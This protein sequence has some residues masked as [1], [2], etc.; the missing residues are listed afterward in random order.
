MVRSSKILGAVSAFALGVAL[1]LAPVWSAPVPSSAT[2]AKPLYK[3]AAAPIESRVD[4]L[5]ARMTLDE[6]I[7]QITTVWTDKIKIFD[8]RLQLDPAMLAAQ[9]PNGLGHFTRPSDGKGSFSP[10]VAPGRNPRQTVVLVNGLQKWA[11]TQTRLGIPILFHEEGLHGYAAVG[12]TSF[13]QSIAMASSFDTDML[14]EVNAVIAR[15]IRARGVSLVL[16]PVVDIA[17]DPRWGRIEE[18]YGEDPYLVGEMGVAAVEGLQG[19]GRSRILPDGHVFA[20]LKHLTGHGQPESGTNVGP[21]PISERELRE[22]FFPPFEQV[23]KR[24]GIEAVMA[25]YNEIDGVPSHANRWLLEDILREEWGFR[26]AVVS[27]YSAVDQLMSI[28]HIAANLDEAAIRA[29]DAGVDADLPDGLSYAALGKLVREGKV[30]EAKIDLAVRRML[31]LKFRAG[32]FENPYADA[33]AAEKITNNPQAR[34]L[35]LTAAQRSIT[36]LK[37]DGMLPLKPEGTI[38]VIGP[39][40]AV[41]RLGGYYGQP[42]HTVSI[43]DGIKAKV[44]AK[45]KIVFAQGVKITEDDDWWADS[46]TK[47]DPAENRKLIAQ[48]V[49]AARHVDRIVLTLGDT[50]QSSREGWADNHLGDRPSLDLV[51]EQQE[52]FDALKALGKP[53]TVVLING[54][55]A[56]T[57][58][59]SEQAN[60]ILEGWY[61]GEQGG[62][63]VAD[64][65]FGD[66]NPGGKLPVTV[67]RSVGQLPIFYNYKPSAHRGYLFDTTDPLYPFGFGLSYTTFDLSAPRLSAA[68]IG[69]GGKTT[70]S[71]DVRNSGP[72]A[73]DE[74]V[75]LYIR[76]KI[77]SVTRPVKE[78][79]GFQRITLKPGE[80]RTVTFTVSPESLQMWN[81]QMQR[82]VEPGDF[83]IMTGNSSVALQTAT[84]TVTP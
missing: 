25:S 81:D 50:E 20:T 18:T 73:G 38:A 52:L 78:L 44:G 58:T 63:A 77:S 1:P 12:A 27:D 43:L 69:I 61:L 84:L 28:H 8:D 34:A 2:T 21:A 45:A 7:A 51:G 22:N 59:V 72:R 15:E 62:N 40:A 70:V 54:R 48:A 83:D 47:S 60:A 64:V 53:I 19:V 67:P 71:V 9:Y 33:A 36:M 66:V 76:D 80:T 74:V 4:D 41:A 31:E 26:G 16:S 29:L 11:M 57:V 23:V 42:P 17:R 35:A 46:V 55:P 49:E 3:N 6:K 56:S 13:P 37:N 32:L 75:Q 39:S 68:K 30:S 79:K 24:T 82:V 10:R 14:R 5:L 65:L